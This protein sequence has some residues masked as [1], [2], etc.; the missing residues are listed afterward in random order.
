LDNGSDRRA[1]TTPLG[2]PGFVNANGD[3]R[4]SVRPSLTGGGNNW[5]NFR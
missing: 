2:K 3:A 4:M 1:A 5:T